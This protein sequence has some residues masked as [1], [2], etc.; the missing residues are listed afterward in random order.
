VGGEVGA[1]AAA[2]EQRATRTAADEGDAWTRQR[3]AFH[4]ARVRQ[5]GHFCI[6]VSRF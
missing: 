1:N 6:A 3:D 2:V 5:T 4:R